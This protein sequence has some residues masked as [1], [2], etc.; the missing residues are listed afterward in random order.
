MLQLGY[1]NPDSTN[2]NDQLIMPEHYISEWQST[3]GVQEQDF[4]PSFFLRLISKMN[5]AGIDKHSIA[6][7]NDFA[8]SPEDEFTHGWGLMSQNALLKPV[9]K[10]IDLLHEI[11]GKG[12]LIEINSSDGLDVFASYNADTL[13]IFFS[14]YSMPNIWYSPSYWKVG[15]SSFDKLLYDTGSLFTAP[16]YISAGLESVYWG[17]NPPGE[18][19]NL[20][21]YFRSEP[22]LLPP[23]SVQMQDQISLGRQQWVEDSLNNAMPH[24]VHINLGNNTNTINGNLIRIDTTHNNTIHIYDSL[25]SIGY[26]HQRAID[27]LQSCTFPG[28]CYGYFW[29]SEEV[30]I[31]GSNYNFPIQPNSVNLLTLPGIDLQFLTEVSSLHRIND[32]PVKV[33][34]VP[35]A[36]RVSFVIDNMNEYFDLMISS[37]TANT[38]YHNPMAN[39]G[40]TIDTHSWKPG[41]YLYKIVTNLGSYSGKIVIQ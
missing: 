9:F 12:Q 17:N 22:V 13:R 1:C 18:W 20:D 25:K 19:G 10:A 23:L 8:P 32:D 40:I 5:Q 21:L 36:T 11:T 16:E 30:T 29:P 26:T 37:L 6:A 14:N 34:P 33:F 41:I 31:S 7:I 24:V 15:W 27:S 3:Y 4:Q 35:T 2:C 39:N 38:I 28:G